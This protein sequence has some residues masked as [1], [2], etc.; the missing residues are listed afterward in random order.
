MRKGNAPYGID[1]RIIQLHHAGQEEPGTMIEALG[2]PHSKSTAMLHDLK[3]N[4]WRH[5]KGAEG[6]RLSNEY[7]NFKKNYW[8]QRALDFED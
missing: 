8:K 4:S 3:S 6:Q 1:D 5:K 2:K 7:T